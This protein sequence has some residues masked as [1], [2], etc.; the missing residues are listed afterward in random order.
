MKKKEEISKNNKKIWEEFVKNPKDMAKLITALRS[1]G[2]EDAA[3]VLS[4][5]ILSAHL[6]KRFAEGR[7][8]GEA[9]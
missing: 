1:V 8:D 2:Q 3:K 4:E 7:V 6:L 9:S 5:E